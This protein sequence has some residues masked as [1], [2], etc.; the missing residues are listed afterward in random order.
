MAY[1]FRYDSISKTRGKNSTNLQINPGTTNE[2]K[3][4]KLCTIKI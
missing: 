1:N 4:S 2:H 3:N